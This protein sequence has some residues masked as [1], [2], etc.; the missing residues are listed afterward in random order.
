MITNGP[1]NAP[2]SSDNKSISNSGSA[3]KGNAYNLKVSVKKQGPGM[4]ISSDGN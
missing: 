2:T 4:E 1:I 3:T